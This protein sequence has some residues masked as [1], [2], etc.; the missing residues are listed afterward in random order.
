MLKLPLEACF[1]CIKAFQSRPSCTSHLPLTPMMAFFARTTS[2]SP[3]GRGQGEG[4]LLRYYQFWSKN[5]QTIKFRCD[6][7]RLHSRKRLVKNG[8]K[9]ATKMVHGVGLK[10]ISAFFL[11]CQVSAGSY[12]TFATSSIFPF[13][14]DLEYFIWPH[15]V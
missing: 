10:A 14:A 13:F 12:S 6:C 11:R 1:S 9:R 2:P 7:P 4:F 3:A 8:F 5:D 15:Q